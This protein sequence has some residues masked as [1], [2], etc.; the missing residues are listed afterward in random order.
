MQ[1]PEEEENEAATLEPKEIIMTN[2]ENPK[3]NHNLYDKIFG[4]KESLPST[5]R[6]SQ[7]TTG[8]GY[9]LVGERVYPFGI[10]QQDDLNGFCLYDNTHQTIKNDT[11][12]T[13]EEEAPL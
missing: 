3:L 6:V 4:K 11:V 10:Q 8:G 12:T 13:C 2:Q 1:T 9:D 7:D 5:K